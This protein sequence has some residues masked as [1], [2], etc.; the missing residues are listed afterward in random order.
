MNFK[1]NR[2]WGKNGVNQ[3]D[4]LPKALSENYIAIDNRNELD[5]LRQIYEY[6]KNIRYYNSNNE[7]KGD[8]TPFFKD[9]YNEEK[10]DIDINK[11]DIQILN[12]EVKPH[13]ALLLSFLKLFKIQQNNLNKITER[14]LQF[15]YK[16][17]LGFTPKQGE[18]GKTTIFLESS[19][20]DGDV[21]IPKGT[22]FD[23]G[24][25]NDGGKI[26]YVSVDDF[27]LNKVKLRNTFLISQ[28]KVKLPNSTNFSSAPKEL[29][30]NYFGF[31]LSSPL[32]EVND[33]ESIK[34]TISTTDT[35]NLTN[36][37]ISY[38]GEK[39][40]IDVKNINGNSFNLTED[41]KAYN[42][43]K[44]GLNLS[45]I[46]PM[47]RFIPKDGL[48]EL[49]NLC[50]NDFK[51]EI[52]VNKGE[53]IT[54]EN[55]YGVILNQ[56]GAMPFGTF[57]KMNDYFFIN[58]VEKATISNITLP[59]SL[60]KLKITT[61]EKYKKVTLN[62]DSYDQQKAAIKIAQ[63]I[64]QYSKDIY[65]N[66]TPGTINTLP[67]ILTLSS[68]IKADYTITCCQDD[69]QIFSLTPYESYE[70]K[71]SSNKGEII[72]QLK[73]TS[74]N[75]E[76]NSNSIQLSFEGVKKPTILSF[77]IRLNPYIVKTNTSKTGWHLLNSNK[78][79]TPINANNIIKD[80]TKN[81]T[82]SGIIYIKITD[83]TI[84]SFSSNGNEILW[85]KASIGDEFSA[86]YIQDIRLNAL[87]LKYD[88]LSE[89]IA[90]PGKELPMG[91][92]TKFVNSI[93]GV[94]KIEQPY[95][96]EMGVPNET[97]EKFK[98]RIS[99]KL[100]HKG[101]AWSPWDYERLVLEKFPEIATV[102]C[103]SN[104]DIEGNVKAG[105]VLI[106]VTPNCNLIKQDNPLQPSI[107]N[108]LINS[109]LDYLKEIASPFVSINISS[110][111]YVEAKIR[112]SVKLKEGYDDTSYYKSVINKEL[113][114]LIAPWSDNSQ[115]V[116]MVNEVNESKIMYFI[117]N[118]Q[119]VDYVENFSIDISPNSEANGNENLY[120]I[121]SADKHDIKIL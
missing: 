8:W 37:L 86:E 52:E 14:H 71:R 98:C 2:I 76:T 29:D 12:G 22:L 113:I 57:C 64:I 68:P 99:E 87:E 85:I 103:I 77:Y 59:E 18:I 66:T 48:D 50:L 89:G 33:G 58:P 80:T 81:F 97:N 63:Q 34:I 9:I 83:E 100:R 69:I 75:L 106:I 74:N 107:G 91:T 36:Y 21:F 30:L 32:L 84:K 41:I 111:H 1:N 23:A 47:L 15:Y 72:S 109:I 117:E 105:N 49:S 10:N 42:S 92:I 88:E 53:N 79:W 116:S 101:K 4:R 94:K 27:T 5:M 13:L 108:E 3:K 110:P 25:D 70:Y 115:D 54:I 120:L 40:W 60:S 102:K 82:Q 56:K 39:D 61:I 16:D 24:K 46:H 104:V 7:E 17:I 119:C 19:Q 93:I 55:K 73:R 43:K 31:I 6:A 51:I 20:K 118:I 26:N 11:L 44:H 35:F 62:T 28:G 112:C 121:T 38:T 67:Q 78:E 96:G 114:K 45:S 65:G 95:C 90:E